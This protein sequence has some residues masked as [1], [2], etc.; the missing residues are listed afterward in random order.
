M[1]YLVESPQILDRFKPLVKEAVGEHSDF[2]NVWANI[3]A[4]CMNWRQW[5]YASSI[6]F[7]AFK[8]QL[9]K[10]IA[11]DFNCDSV[12]TNKA[13][14]AFIVAETVAGG[15]EI[16]ARNWRGVWAVHPITD[17]YITDK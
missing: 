13:I 1:G 6:S 7:L 9:V 11:E 15:N 10:K 3:T 17:R 14:I 8:M 16:R 5:R 12:R 2:E 4:Y